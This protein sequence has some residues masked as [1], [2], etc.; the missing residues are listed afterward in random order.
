MVRKTP[1][2]LSQIEKQLGSSSLHKLV[3][4]RKNQSR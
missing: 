4:L 3:I 1:D 2:K